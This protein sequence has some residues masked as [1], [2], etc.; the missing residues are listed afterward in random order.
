V[1]EASCGLVE[2]M[3]GILGLVRAQ[4]STFFVSLATGWVL[5]GVDEV[6]EALWRVGHCTTPI[7]GLVATSL[8][9]P[10]YSSDIILPR[11]SWGTPGC[12]RVD[13][14]A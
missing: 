14:T 13:P 6:V 12:N 8:D 7:Q 3:F 10:A 2:G 4:P 9:S 5:C 11:R 1:L